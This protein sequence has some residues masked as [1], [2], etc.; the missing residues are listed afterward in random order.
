MTTAITPKRYLTVAAV[1]SGAGTAFAGYLSYERASSGICAFAESCP[2]ILGQPACYTGLALFAAAFLI[3]VTALAVKVDVVWP[4]A[5][6]VALAIG[7]TLLSSWLTR[8]ELLSHNGYR[9]GLSTC[10]YGMLFFIA[11]LIWSLSAAELAT[12]SQTPP[13]EV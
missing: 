3:S 1:L 7:G 10:A 5:I 9:L 11:L 6:N 2:L 12:P 13:L 8:D 4:R